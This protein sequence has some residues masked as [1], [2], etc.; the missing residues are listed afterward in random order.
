MQ[1]ISDDLWD[2][3]LVPMMT[4]D[5]IETLRQ[6]SRRFRE[7]MRVVC[8]R[9]RFRSHHPY[10]ISLRAREIEFLF[11]FVHSHSIYTARIAAAFVEAI[12]PR[13]QGW[14]YLDHVLMREEHELCRKLGP[15]CLQERLKICEQTQMAELK[16]DDNGDDTS[17]DSAKLWK[18]K[19]FPACFMCPVPSPP[20]TMDLF[21]EI[22]RVDGEIC[23]ETF[24][25]V[26]GYNAK[27]RSL[28]TDPDFAKIKYEDH[29]VCIIE[30]VHQ[31]EALA[32]VWRTYHH[33]DLIEGMD[34]NEF[35]VWGLRIPL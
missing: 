1:H 26:M 10:Y 32:R 33:P 11:D 31:V 17:A 3:A 12:Y 29:Q 2:L 4:A 23:E 6:V 21:Y 28:F 9:P 15:V 30:T 24:A 19:L 35:A 14:E 27:D 20:L 8:P 18:I 16:A 22:F 5:T 25:I 13:K 7:L 34:A